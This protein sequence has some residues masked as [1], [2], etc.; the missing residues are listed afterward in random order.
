MRCFLGG[1]FVTPPAG[2]EPPDPVGG[3]EPTE[4]GLALPSVYAITIT[5]P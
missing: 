2:G 1:I 5:P 3:P 4:T